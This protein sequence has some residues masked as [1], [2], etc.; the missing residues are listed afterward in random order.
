MACHWPLWDMLPHFNST[1]KC[2]INFTWAELDL[3]VKE[4]ESMTR[5]GN[6]PKSFRDKGVLPVDGMV[7]PEDYEAAKANFAK[8][9]EIFVGLAKDEEERELF[10]KLWPYQNQESE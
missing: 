4:G 10:N 9:N 6:M 1:T 2:R 5:I 3:H 8:C 7:D